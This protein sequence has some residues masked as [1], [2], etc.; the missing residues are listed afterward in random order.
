[1][2]QILL[3]VHRY[4]YYRHLLPAVF[5]NYFHENQTVYSHNTRNRTNLHL[6]GVNSMFG[7]KCIKF[8]FKGAALW[9]DLPTSIK[10]IASFNK[11]LKKIL[12]N[13][14]SSQYNK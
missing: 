11:F 14:L 10:S 7:K 2:Q 12:K 9:N 13:Y 8:N 5:V 6:Y 1:M 3:F 4:V